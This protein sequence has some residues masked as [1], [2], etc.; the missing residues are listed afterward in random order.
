V[1]RR[2]LLGHLLLIGGALVTLY[3]LLWMAASSVKP[4]EEIFSGSGLWPK[5]FTLDNYRAGWSALGVRFW[6]F[7]G[8]SFVIAL[9]AIAGNVLSCSMA[10]YAFARLRFAFRRL[11]FGV[12]LATLMLPVHVLIIPQYTL[13]HRLGWI[14][15]F[16]PLIVPK[17]LAVDGFFIFLMTQ[18]IRALPTELDDA[19]RIDGCGPVRIYLRIILPLMRPALITTA[20]F[21][22]VWTWDDF[23]SQLV[24][25]NG[26][27]HYTVPLALR[28]FLDATGQSSWGQLLAMA[29]LALVPVLVFFVVFQRRITDGIST[30]GLPG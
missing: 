30:T 17:F 5:R 14:D 7:F 25:L 4:T 26:V 6:V 9:A 23:F 11:W 29:T 15:T 16:L 10:A 22:F 18:F 3:P 19:A 8:N 13:F 24:Y 27:E 1:T 20:I 2:R 21:T 28:S 12:M